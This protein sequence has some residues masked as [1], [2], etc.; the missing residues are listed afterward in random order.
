MGGSTRVNVGNE[1][2]FKATNE[3]EPTWPEGWDHDL[4]E[5]PR[6]ER[7]KPAKLGGISCWRQ[8][9]SAIPL[10]TFGENLAPS[11]AWVTMAL[12]ARRT[13]YPARIRGNRATVVG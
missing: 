8:I 6:V 4:E 12:K 13:R 11:V 9:V 10:I 1:A 7:G 2:S 3:D 5:C